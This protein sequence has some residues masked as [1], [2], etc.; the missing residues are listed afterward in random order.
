MNFTNSTELGHV[1]GAM[2][3]I[4][5][6]GTNRASYFDSAVKTMYDAQGSVT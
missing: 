2:S 4:D 6:T 5:T 3:T 1:N